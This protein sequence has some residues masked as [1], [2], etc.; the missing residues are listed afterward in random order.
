MEKKKSPGCFSI[1][2]GIILIVILIAVFS[3]DPKDSGSNIPDKTEAYSTNGL[4]V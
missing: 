2:A 3:S 4:T 1:L